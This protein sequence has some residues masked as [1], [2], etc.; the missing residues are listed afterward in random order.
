MVDIG[1]LVYMDKSLHKVVGIV[2]DKKIVPASPY[3]APIDFVPDYKNGYPE[4]LIVKVVMT[5]GEAQWINPKLL[6]LINQGNGGT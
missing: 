3:G 4:A 6:S 5:C 1:D 2:V